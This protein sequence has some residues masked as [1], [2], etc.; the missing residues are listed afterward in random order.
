MLKLNA[1]LS[2][3]LFINTFIILML[4]GYSW[5]QRKVN[6][7]IPLLLLN[8]AA[9]FYSFGYAMELLSDTVVSID[10]WSRFQ[11][12]GLPFIPILWI[13]LAKSYTRNLTKKDIFILS[14]AGIPSLVT[15]IMRM[16][17]NYH[18]WMYVD[19]SLVS[20]GYFNVLEFSKG[21]WYYLH[22]IYF[23]LCAGYAIYLYLN[24]FK[25][26]S[27]I[28][29]HQIRIMVIASLMPF[30]SIFI[31]LS[32]A[33]PLGLDSGPFFILFDYLLFT[34]GIFRYS[35]ILLIPLSRERV[36]EWIYDGV[37]VIDLN[38]NLIDFNQAAHHIFPSLSK[39]M[40]GMPPE[41]MDAFHPDFI[42]LLLDRKSG[43][44]KPIHNTS[45]PMEDAQYEYSMRHPNTDKTHFY[46]VRFKDLKNHDIIV[47]TAI[48][49]SDITAT[50]EMMAQL[51]QAAQQDVLT[52][53]YN[54]R[55]FIDCA[56]KKMSQLNAEN[57]D[58]VLVLFD[59]D[60]FKIV[61]DTYGHQAGDLIL[62]VIAELTLQK[63][64]S[65]GFAGRY[66]GE[67]FIIF[68]PQTDVETAWQ[69]VESIRKAFEIQRT[70]WD[71]ALISVTASFGLTAFKS[72]SNA[73]LKSFDQMVKEADEAMYKAKQLGRNRI[74]DYSD[75]LYESII[76]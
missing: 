42:Q 5:K 44:L 36:F 12:I 54:R 73:T 62:K 25:A 33:F 28:H 10:L 47:G 43:M 49:I 16:T 27:G 75:C 72:A 23:I 64:D 61:N 20:N 7:A 35:M 52:G 65:S 57:K 8:I 56:N 55:H 63:L 15:C 50:K 45:E 67:E 18:D 74:E 13:L 3:L 21:P 66:G 29:K 39:N 26:V 6:G 38:H 37:I 17:S 68:L 69:T 1:M 14:I 46:K 30:I 31:N 51:E 76:D 32:G 58:G 34:L 59:I 53:L 60:H 22:F 41:P 48:M 71:T 9:A 24:R 2:S 11:Y 19:M 70:P 40:I 4:A